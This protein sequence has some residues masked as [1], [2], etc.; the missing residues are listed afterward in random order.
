MDLGPIVL[1]NVGLTCAV[2]F[3]R[4]LA[5][6]P[7]A[8]GWLLVSSVLLSACALG[9]LLNVA[10]DSLALW[11]GLA[12]GVTVALPMFGMFRIQRAV[13]RQ[14]YQS[15][16][17]WAQ[18]CAVLHPA[19]GLREQ[20]RLI[21]ALAL[22]QAGKRDEAERL[23]S[24]QRLSGPLARIFQQQLF[25]LR[26][27]WQDIVQWG[28]GSDLS[29]GLQAVASG[30]SELTRDPVGLALVMRALG[31]VGRQDAMVELAQVSGRL[32]MGKGTV[33]HLARLFLFAF[34]GRLEA[35][36]ALLAGPLVGYTHEVKQYWLATA[37][38]ALGDAPAAAGR[39][40]ELMRS[41]DA[42]VRAQ[43]EA[44]LEQARTGHSPWPP[45]SESARRAL[46]VA[47]VSSEQELRFSPA[48]ASPRSPATWSLI[49]LNAAVFLALSPDGEWFNAGVLDPRDF[50]QGQYWRLGS[51][52]FL[53]ENW[54][55]LGLNA[56]SLWWLGRYAERALGPARYAATY[57]AAG[58]LSG[59]PYLVLLQVTGSSPSVI[60]ASGAVMGMLGAAGAVL[61]RGWRTERAPVGRLLTQLAAI[62]TIQVVVDLT[63]PRV[64]MG[65]HLVGMVAGFL[66]ASIVRHPGTSGASAPG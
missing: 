60:G 45:L 1:W 21:Q 23:L 38:L 36:K 7:R 3:L 35:V 6:R 9:L 18:L 16:L 44:R 2:L 33:F 51:F 19:D 24:Q 58:A 15:G 5:S 17:R 29:A 37:E 12:W 43:A 52:L 41:D 40:A 49:A 10:L 48:T 61:L 26:G 64:A 59:V 65:A 54:L 46:E 53:H 14:Q 30:K 28:L 50:F 22:A 27:D 8:W 34:T 25:K 47:E 31:E 13:Q 55:H 11:V 42:V 39:L 20:P 62:V 57:A 56:I 63:S 66:I 4:S 32:L